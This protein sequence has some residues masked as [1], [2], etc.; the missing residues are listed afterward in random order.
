[1][2]PLRAA[3]LAA[4]LVAS[5]VPLPPAAAI[6]RAP[7]W[8]R[9]GE[10]KVHPGLVLDT[11]GSDCTSNFVFAD[12][13]QHVY[14][15]Q[16]AHCSSQGDDVDFDGCKEKTVPLGTQVRIVG[17]D[18]A[19]SLVYNSWRTMQAR[20]E[21][22]AAAC[23]DND[24]ALVALPDSVRAQV[25]PDVPYF[26]GPHGLNTTGVAGAEA[27]YSYGNSP[28][29]GGIGVLAPKR[30]A[31]VTTIDSGWSYLVYFATPGIP[32]DSG[33][34]VLDSTGRA[35]GVMSSLITTPTPGS[36]GVADLWRMLS[37]AQEWSEIKGLRLVDGAQ[38]FAADL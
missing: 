38:P 31:V 15:G 12:A 17:S 3:T 16:A 13:D 21:T 18:I 22:N 4:V 9:P 36:N 35:L 37:Y 7:L 2:R 5:V 14:L 6:S 1:V 34:A 32:G 20:H 23:A 30:G 8:A 10:A 26:G 27:V 24:F 11:A 28:L 19:G 33:S 25:S 29:R